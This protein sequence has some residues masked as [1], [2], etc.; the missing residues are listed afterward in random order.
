MLFIRLRDDRPL[1]EQV[2]RVANQRSLLPAKLST[3]P[4]PAQIAKH[5]KRPARFGW[6]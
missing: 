5:E 2:I 6:R 4:E 3:I 1:V